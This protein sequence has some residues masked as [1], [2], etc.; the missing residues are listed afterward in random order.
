MAGKQ[1]G[2]KDER[3]GKQQEQ[4]GN[5]GQ[6]EARQ[7]KKKDQDLSHMGEMTRENQRSGKD[8]G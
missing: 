1:M 2:E 3:S 8:K 4:Q 6:K 5:L 7:E